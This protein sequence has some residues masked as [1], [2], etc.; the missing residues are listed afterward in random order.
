M[1]SLFVIILLLQVQFFLKN[2]EK[3]IGEFDKVSLIRDCVTTKPSENS[4][5]A[6]I[7]FQNLLHPSPTLFIRHWNEEKLE[8]M[9]VGPEIFHSYIQLILFSFMEEYEAM[10]ITDE[11]RVNLPLIYNKTCKF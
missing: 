1:K 7:H 6:K 9:K 8:D 10:S 11:C 5:R 4:A 2:F 3:F